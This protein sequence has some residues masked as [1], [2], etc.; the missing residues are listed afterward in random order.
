MIKKQCIII[1]A[2]NEE[3]RIG[4]VIENIRG[5]SD[6]DII[7]IDDGSKDSTAVKAEKAGAGR[8]A[9]NERRRPKPGQ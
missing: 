2:Y 7:V 9:G 5:C 1:P 3:N 6:A 4:S 8:A